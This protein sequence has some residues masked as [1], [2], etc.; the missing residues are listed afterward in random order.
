MR[1]AE[2]IERL[3]TGLQDHASAD[4]DR[5]TLEDMFSVQETSTSG[6]PARSWQDIGR[7]IVHSRIA[8]LAAAAVLVLAVL[9]LARHLAGHEKA[10]TPG[11]NNETIAQT[12]P[13][14]GMPTPPAVVP[15][16]EHLL[17]AQERAAREYFGK[18]D[19]K[20]LLELLETG[21]DQTK[22]VVA[23]YLAQ[24]GEGSAIPALEK[25]A[26]QW[27]GPASDNPFR[28]SIERI[29]TG[30][31]RPDKAGTKVPTKEETPVNPS[32]ATSSDLTIT[33]RVSEKTTGEPIPNA[34]L[35][36]WVSSVWQTDTCDEKGTFVVNVGES[37]PK[38]VAIAA[39]PEGYV[40]QTVSLRD[41]SPK[42]LPKTIEFPLDKGTVIGG[43]VRD[44][45]GRPVPG[46][47]VEAYISEPQK[48]DQ[49][50]VSVSIE[51]TTD[52]QGRWRFTGVPA[53][54]DSLS[55]NVSHAQFA[56][57]SFEMPA[58][59][60]LD[61][62]RAERAV[63]VLKEGITVAGRV[64]DTAGNPIVGAELL[65]GQD[66]NGRDWT[67]TD[68]AG[69]FEFPHLRT[70]AE[71]FLLTVQAKGF[72][73][74]RR[75]LPSQKGLA[76]VQFVLPP[77][78][79]LLGHVV[80][81]AGYPVEGVYVATQ[82]WNQ[83][84][85][86]RWS[87]R[88][89][90]QGTFVWDYAP[91]DA[92]EI[93]L[94]KEGYRDIAQ[95]VVANDREQTFILAKPMTIRGSVTDSKTG[96]PVSRFKLTPG[97]EDARGG[98]AKWQPSDSW[99]RWFTDGRYSYTF[100]ADAQAY[101]VRIEAEGYAPVESRFVDANE[102]GATIDVVL[103]KGEGPS[104]YVFDAEAHPVAG[105]EVCWASRASIQ[106]GQVLNTSGVARTTTGGDGHFA[107]PADGQK[108][109]LFVLCDQGMGI[110]SWEDF[111]KTGV[112]T[113]TPWAHV[114]GDLCLGRQP[115]AGRKLQLAC[116][117]KLIPDNISA[118][119]ETTTDG[120][121][122]FA[123]ERVYPG[124]F[125]L[126]NQA[127]Y[128]LPGQTLELHLGGTG[129]TVKGQLVLP[130]LADTPIGN[131]LV[132]RPRVNIPFD[133][134]PQPPG[135][136]QMSL[137]EVRAWFDRWSK[138]QESRIYRDRLIKTYPQIAQRSLPVEIDGPLTFHADNV[139]PGIY[140]L[141]GV[142]RYSQVHASSRGNEILGRLGYEF[143]VPLLL[144]ESELDVPLDLG[145]LTVL[146]GELKP[147]DPAP[148][149]DV[150]TFG[151][152]RLRLQDYRGKV[153]VVSFYSS[154][155]AIGNSPAMKDLKDTYQRFHNN[156]RF[157][158]IGL[159][160]GEYPP[161]APKVVAEEG[162]DWPHGLV[163]YDGKESTEYSVPGSSV[164]NILISPRGEILGV[165]LS[166]AA[167]TQ[168]IEQA[169]RTGL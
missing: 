129:R 31:A 53:R 85:T 36:F 169:L 120:N 110:V 152:N 90:A 57:G 111:A 17:E 137:A 30:S 159:L 101:G 151:P 50:H 154:Q 118:R 161:L 89:D 94:E 157:A 139:E 22:I 6:L 167:M 145:P 100:S 15:Q 16:Q 88:T 99:T 74:Q 26:A 133:R 39:R 10:I 84:R 134:F 66:Y 123:F 107:F 93:R 86:L 67:T 122:R 65:A 49:P 116:Y 63:L 32:G 104:G 44:S 132:V 112:V 95:E 147:G 48:S 61:D 156:P 106:N 146:P 121:G 1:P 102:V 138:S 127:Y 136:E 29:Q 41:L 14:E 35:R 153:L 71:S 51:E 72:T 150:P 70:L 166:G 9:L 24:M 40:W 11:W 33:V 155:S 168:A 68:A 2:E 64:T 69:H 109:F 163:A 5:R 13:K 91:A 78:K 126:Y 98:L 148:D 42:E 141:T 21:Q 113:L 143:E 83:Y 46:A 77:A 144:Q 87:S 165:G 79:M 97:L 73:P 47:S 103:T 160:I 105:V 54:L 119:C 149:F 62:L 114:Q 81:T 142:I 8:K 92:I 124:D 56:D 23:G 108:D 60:K 4:F 140:T 82:R 12:T 25:L 128:V 7:A 80:D 162:W 37:V 117:N 3:L 131:T 43:V 45:A 76:P 130:G 135:Y 96:Q 27:T 18:A 19:A 164:R 158:Q 55:F 34:A 58:N 59:L 38:A 125:T 75:E 20:G 52:D 28:R 115:G